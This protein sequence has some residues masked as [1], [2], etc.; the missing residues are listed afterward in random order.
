MSATYLKLILPH[1]V[2]MP[3]TPIHLTNCDREPIHIPGKIQAHGYLAAI[4]KSDLSISYISENV[5]ELTGI[6]LED[7][8]KG[9]INALFATNAI[10]LRNAHLAQLKDFIADE[11][12]VKLPPLNIRIKNAPYFLIVHK[13]G[14]NLILEFEPGNNGHSI[15]LQQMIGSSVSQILEGNTINR[16]LINA[17]RQIKQIIGYERVMIYK[18][19]DD[20]H[21]EVVAEEKEEGLE[22]FLGL[23]YPASD[24]PKQ[25]RE[26]YKVN[27]VR[28]IADVGSTPVPIAAAGSK[29]AVI[30]LDLTQSTLRAVSPVHI[31]YLKNMEV[32][33]SFSI[34]LI[35]NNELWGLVACHNSVPKFIDYKAREGAKLI[36][37]ILSSSIEYKSSEEGREALRLFN[38]ASL[39]ILRFLQSSDSVAEALTQPTYNLLSITNAKGAAVVFD[40]EIRT[41]GT[42]PSQEQI[43]KL[44]KWLSKNVNQQIYSTESLVNVY[45]GAREIKSVS[46]GLLSCELSREMGEYILWFKPEILHTVNWAGNPSKQ[47]SINEKGEVKIS[48][49]ESF[50]TWRE[51]VSNTSER[52]KRNEFAA[53]IKLREYIIQAISQKAN[54]IRILNE[55]LQIAYEELDTFS[56]TISHDLKTPL[57]SVKN[58]TEILLEE[59]KT[60]NEDE[61]GMLKRI[62][63]GAEKM[64][65]LI[66]EVLAYSRI[67]R[68]EVNMQVVDMKTLITEI[69]NELKSIYTTPSPQII[70]GDT[71]NINGDKTM[72]LQVFTNLLSNAVKYSSKKE[73]PVI[74]ISGE[75]LPQEVIYSIADNGVGIDMSFG[76][77]IF[78]IFRRL[79]NA[80]VF[81]GTGVGL[82]I[83]KRI[84]EKH[85]GRIWYESELG[86]GTVF[87]ISFN[88]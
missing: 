57:A 34:S 77:Q 51:Q 27:L 83:V 75:D 9:D 86:V 21:G 66:N 62:V 5:A 16:S 37:Q 26:L 50:E 43:E 87:Y 47:E 82:S 32:M 10:Q 7:L 2:I 67:G 79:N 64:N 25:A 59:N 14:N 52:W 38:N 35:V 85:K 3:D 72:I 48:P 49:R 12:E 58:Y 41:L 19:W 71:P 1:S 42:T 18:F 88:K 31:E 69:T 13:S 11:H 70:I 63:K 81:E 17:A 15:E 20:G 29:Q 24:I 40:K 33:A 8:V 76:N 80:N 61:V 44:V 6:P 78:E 68:K 60:F 55:K 22:P 84:V 54:Q 53:V 56:F 4:D 39:E 30:P 28:I 74:K 46:S 23:H 45:E 73:R 36:G 65:V